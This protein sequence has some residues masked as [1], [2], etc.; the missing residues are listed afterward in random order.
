MI[1][2]GTDAGGAIEVYTCVEDEFFIERGGGSDYH[3]WDDNYIAFNPLTTTIEG[4]YGVVVYTGGIEYCNAPNIQ[5]D[6]IISLGYG[7]SNAYEFISPCFLIVLINA[8]SAYILSAVFMGNM[9]LEKVIGQIQ[10]LPR[11]YDASSF[12]AFSNIG[13]MPTI[14]IVEN[15][16][17]I[18]FSR[19]A[20]NNKKIKY[21]QLSVPIQKCYFELSFA[22]CLSLETIDII[23]HT[24]YLYRT[25]YNAQ[26]LKSVKQIS[27]LDN[28]STNYAFR[29]CHALEEIELTN[30]HT[31]SLSFEH[32][33][34]LS[35]E[36]INR[37]IENCDK[38]G[39]T[40]VARTLTLHATAGARWADET[41]NPRY[42]E[43]L[44]KANQC[45]IQIIY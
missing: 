23:G 25:F 32:S 31:L 43:L 8:I 14:N 20:F 30:W 4:R 33:P 12:L 19:F 42:T 6:V 16:K 36:S 17:I 29:Y 39:G 3:Y 15:A 24:N 28:I 35:I 2:Q 37:L 27:L 13:I 22:G 1:E 10:L 9:L 21:I 5:A 41:Q 26:K 44:T 40:Q 34:N 11:D 45:L 38:D 18:S 7:I